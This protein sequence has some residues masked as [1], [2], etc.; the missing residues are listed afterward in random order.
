M[1]FGLTINMY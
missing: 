1:V